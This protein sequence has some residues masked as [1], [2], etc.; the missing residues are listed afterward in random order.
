[1]NKIEEGEE[2]NVGGMD[3]VLIGDENTQNIRNIVRSIERIEKIIKMDFV[4][5]LMITICFLC[6]VGLLTFF[7]TR[8][9]Y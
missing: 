3:D 2:D 6:L 9:F 7:F 1:M 8:K 5:R 4:F